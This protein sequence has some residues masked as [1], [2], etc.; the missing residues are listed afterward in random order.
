VKLMEDITLY[1]I[2]HF[3]FVIPWLIPGNLSKYHFHVILLKLFQNH[4]V[5]N[6]IM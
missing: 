4:I 6:I 3:M 2:G 5:I 1:N